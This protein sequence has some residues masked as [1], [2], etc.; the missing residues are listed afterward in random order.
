[1]VCWSKPSHNAVKVN[2]KGVFD[3]AQMK[4]AVGC[5]MRNSQGQWVRGAAGMIGLALPLAAEI[6]SIYY[7]LKLAWERGDVSNVIIKCD[8]EEAVN[9]VNNLDPDFWLLDLV[10]LIKN[11]ENEAWD[12]CVIQHVPKTCNA[13][14]TVL[15]ESEID[16]NGDAP[17]FMS[18]VLAA[19]ET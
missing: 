13:P 3:R 2:C 4:A 6:W 8:D 16:G 5:V 17:G 1:M 7:G 19:D 18:S 11:L 9:H 12:S 14:A 10:L 15:A